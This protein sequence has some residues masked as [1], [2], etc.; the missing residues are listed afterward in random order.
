MEGCAKPGRVGPVLGVHRPDLC[1]DGWGRWGG[2]RQEGSQT[3]GPPE[4][5]GTDS[6]I[7]PQRLDLELG[8]KEA[9]A[10]EPS[11]SLGWDAPHPSAQSPTEYQRAS[12]RWFSPECARLD[13]AL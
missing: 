1:G 5:K 6:S 3:Q 8:A 12:G 13:K 7:F 11:Q 2:G 4:M 9:V 10:A